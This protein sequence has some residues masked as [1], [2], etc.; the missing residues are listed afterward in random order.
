MKEKEETEEEYN[1]DGDGMTNKIK[2]GRR[3]GGERRRKS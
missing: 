2:Q 3:G 1:D